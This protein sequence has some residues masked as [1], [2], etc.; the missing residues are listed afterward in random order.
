MHSIRAQL[1]TLLT[2][3]GYEPVLSD[4]ADV[5]YDPRSHTHTSCVREI[6]NCDMVIVVIGSRF[7]GSSIPKAL[8]LID[9]TRIAD[10]SRAENFAEDKGKISITQA[11]VLRAIQTGL[12]VFAFVDSGVMRDHLT[13]EKN[14]AKTIISQIDFSSIEKRETAPY[15]FEFI[16]FLR[17]RNE[18]NSIFEFSRFEDI[19]TQIKKQW[20]GLFQRLLHEQR[21]HAIE[22]R[23]IDNLSSQIADLK[24]A[25]LGSISSNELKETAKG[26]IRY[27]VMVDFLSSAASAVTPF[28]DVWALLVSQ[29]SWE[30]V[31]AIFGIKE[32]RAEARSRNIGLH[33]V[34]LR[35]DGTYYRVRLSMSGI[36]RL[37]REWSDFK[38][39]GKDAKEAIANAV[40][41]SR[42]GRLSFLVRFYN[43]PYVEDTSSSQDE[44]MDIDVPGAQA[45]ADSRILLT[46]EKFIEESVK[47]HLSASP[48]FKGMQF[49]V[50]VKNKSVE[51]VVL[52]NNLI[53]KSSQL[54]YEYE[55]NTDGK[56]ADVLEKITSSIDTDLERL[57]SAKEGPT[58]E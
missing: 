14:K 2:G 22:T 13:Y 35:E 43:E 39:L 15:I 57:K 55:P 50:D 40:I 27:R 7:G 38:E 28:V 23:R 37:G 8:E 49:L 10:W 47:N 52:P 53:E 48:S 19:E 33:S 24:A 1:R 30:E 54:T 5:L 3:L 20:A 21:E 17:L 41:D 58:G 32:I 34:M 56:L 25:V 6:E 29:L 45:V 18:N 51:I 11:E 9:L 16:N 4:Q 42:Q 31:F 12:P 36:A 44:D 26:A 46:Q